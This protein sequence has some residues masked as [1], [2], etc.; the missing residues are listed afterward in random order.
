M[1]GRFESDSMLV[2]NKTGWPIIARYVVYQMYENCLKDVDCKAQQR[3][4]FTE[5][6]TDKDR[7]TDG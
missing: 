5:N 6:V 3:R 2:S 7:M 4:L 1:T